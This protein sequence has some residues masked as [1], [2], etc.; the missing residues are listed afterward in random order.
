MKKNENNL[1]CDD[2]TTGVWCECGNEP[3]VASEQIYRC[4]KCGRGY[5]TEFNIY[6]YEAD[7][8]DERYK[9]V[10]EIGLKYKLK[11]ERRHETTTT[12]YTKAAE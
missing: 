5:R 10:P 1:T 2:H 8:H 7:E 3:F 11:S 4:Y 9:D 12:T 6:C